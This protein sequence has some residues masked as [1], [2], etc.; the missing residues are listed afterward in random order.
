EF[1]RALAAA[2]HRSRASHRQPGADQAGQRSLRRDRAACQLLHPD[3]DSAGRKRQAA[4]RLENRRER[5]ADRADRGTVARSPARA[6]DGAA[7]AAADRRP[8]LTYFFAGAAAA[9]AA[10]PICGLTM[11]PFAFCSAM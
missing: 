10:G 8:T 9:W 1:R 4:A 7:L 5:E 3:A 11:T 6:A 2:Q